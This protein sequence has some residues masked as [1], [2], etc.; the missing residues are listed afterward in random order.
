MRRAPAEGLLL[1]T[2]LLVAT[3]LTITVNERLP[4]IATLRA[5]LEKHRGQ[6]QQ[7]RTSAESFLKT[8][9]TPPPSDLDAAE[10]A[11]W[12]NVARALLNL[13]ETMTRS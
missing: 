13:H 2:V 5:L 1:V 6:Y 9:A 10:L 4:E 12:T 8:G 3:L 11:A 7:D